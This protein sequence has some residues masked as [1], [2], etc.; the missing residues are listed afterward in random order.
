M[1]R[2]WTD[3]DAFEA[4]I[5]GGGLVE[6]DDGM[7]DAYRRAVFAFIEMHANS[8]LMGAL[9]E[10]DW[11]PKTPGLRHKMAV[12]AKTQDEIGHGHLLYMIAADLGVKTRTQMLED[13]FAGRSRFHNVFHYRAV[14]WGDQVAIAFLV[15]AAALISQQAVFKNCSYGPYRRILRRIITE[16]G[17]HMRLG[18]DRMMRIAE[19]TARQRSMFQESLD[20]W[21]W[22]ALQLFGPDS[23][24]D[25]E[26]LRWRIKSERNEVLRDRWVQRFVPMLQSYGFT[27]PAPDLRWD[28]EAERWDVGP[29]DWGPLERTLAH[30]GP[31]SAR[32][33]ADAADNWSRTAWARAALS[34]GSSGA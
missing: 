1:P 23:V 8:E 33:I 19:G 12:L 16:E 13:L 26:L 15:D 3:M 14:T 24:P 21:F 28:T 11:I 10:R 4:F 22:P 31:D 2:C 7:P 9:T 34:N 30:G 5:D 29:I 25:D 32:R 18:E 20:R 17:F 27:V 6:A